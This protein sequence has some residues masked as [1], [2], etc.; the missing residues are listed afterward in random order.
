MGNRLMDAA[1]DG[2]AFAGV[3]LVSYGAW[4]VYKPAGFIACG[5]LLLAVSVVGVFRGR[6]E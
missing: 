1:R 6:G 3:G 2:L 4:L 5:V